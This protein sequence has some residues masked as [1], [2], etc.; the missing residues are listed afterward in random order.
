MNIKNLLTILIIAIV[1]IACSDDNNKIISSSKDRN[2]LPEN[3]LVGEWYEVSSTDSKGIKVIFAETSF[4]AYQYLKDYNHS[5]LGILN[6]TNFY[7]NNIEYSVLSDDELFDYEI[8]YF[9][10]HYY[11]YFDNAKDWLQINDPEITL[12]QAGGRHL[13]NFIFVNDTL[14]INNFILT[15]AAVAYPCNYELIKLLRR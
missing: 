15:T 8:N 13:S 3:S 2:E 9:K 6:D 5:V 12:V 7:Y 10:K 1:I 4:T 11:W 14:I